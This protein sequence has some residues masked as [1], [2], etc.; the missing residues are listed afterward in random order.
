VKYREAE[1]KL[2]ELGCIEAPRRGGGSH[3]K[4]RNPVN[5]RSTVL[6]DWGSRDIKAGTWR[7]VVRQL[8]LDWNS[9]AAA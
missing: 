9:F 7:A 8:G 2:K 3:R 6:P 4:W 1:R 5:G